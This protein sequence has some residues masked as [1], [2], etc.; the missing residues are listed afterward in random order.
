VLQRLS[1]LCVFYVQSGFDSVVKYPISYV[2][3]GELDRANQL[4]AL[5][6][7]MIPIPPVLA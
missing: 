7:P 1:T 6:Y 2:L 3:V 5:L 4:K